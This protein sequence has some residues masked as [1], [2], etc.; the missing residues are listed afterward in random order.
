MRKLTPNGLRRL[1]HRESVIT[2][3]RNT[4]S[5]PIFVDF[6]LAIVS[7][8]SKT[9]SLWLSTRDRTMASTASSSSGGTSHL[10]PDVDRL[11]SVKEVGQWLGVAPITVRR[12]VASGNLPKPIVFRGSGGHPQT[13]RWR[14]SAIERFVEARERGSDGSES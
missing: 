12:Y 1:T 2:L 8:V 4:Q 14:Q 11:L 9:P 13:H 6:R 5:E 3:D 7:Q 10:P